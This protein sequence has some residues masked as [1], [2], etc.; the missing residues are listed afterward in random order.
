MTYDVQEAAAAGPSAADRW[1][2][3]PKFYKNVGCS[4]N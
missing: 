1:A 4:F 2:A 3:V